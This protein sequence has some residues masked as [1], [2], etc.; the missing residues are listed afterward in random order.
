MNDD[1]LPVGTALKTVTRVAET[2]PWLPRNKNTFKSSSAFVG[3][4]EN[5][6]NT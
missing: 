5:T 2:R 4:F 1:Y 3:L 6:L